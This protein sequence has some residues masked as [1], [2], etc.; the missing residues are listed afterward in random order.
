MSIAI[1][2]ITYNRPDDALELAQ[3]I[4]QLQNV[5]TLCSEVIFVNNKSTVP[6]T[7]LEAFI[8]QHPQI[9]FR[10]FKT[11][12]NLG[13]SRGRNF[14]IQQTTAP[15]LVFLDDDALFS[16]LDALQYIQQIFTGWV[17]ESNRPTGIISFK[18]YYHSTGELQKTAFPHKQFERRKDWHHFQTGYFVGCAHAIHRDVFAKTGYY[19]VNFFYGMEEYDLSYRAI[20][21]GFDIVYDDR[22]VILHKESPLGRQPNHEKLRGMW[23]NKTKVA[24]K[25]LPFIYFVTTAILWS[26]EYLKKTAYL[27]G[28]LKGWFQIFGIPG[29]EKR[30]PVNK[31][32]LNY[33]KKVEARLW[34]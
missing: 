1:V 30:K 32:G 28:W 13:V 17:I 25:Y 29:S 8:T 14:A 34:Y 26:F 31:T 16:N 24:W 11:E 2:I 19:P 33:L 7:A 5:T 21:A 18:V 3:N 9:P 22:V 6:Y 27:P 23:V 4:S 20:E 12:E 10:Y 15:Y